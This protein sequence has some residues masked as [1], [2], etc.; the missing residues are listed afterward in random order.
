MVPLARSE[1]SH[2]LHV[3]AFEWLGFILIEITGQFNEVKFPR[4]WKI[5]RVHDFWRTGWVNGNM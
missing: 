3:F 4:G 2:H 1:R 5:F